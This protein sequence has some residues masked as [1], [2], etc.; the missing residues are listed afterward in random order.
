MFTQIQ[1]SPWVPELEP[2]GAHW[3]PFQI[4]ITKLPKKRSPVLDILA[5]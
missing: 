1:S 3:V 5:L 2:V 4:V